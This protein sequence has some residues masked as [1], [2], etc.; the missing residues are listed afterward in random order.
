MKA[1]GYSELTTAELPDSLEFRVIWHFGWV[2]FIRPVFYVAFVLFILMANILKHLTA[3]DI[4][5]SLSGVLIMTFI[6][7]DHAAKWFQGRT[8]TLR[9]TDNELVASGN[10][11]RLFL[12]KV[13]IP[14]PEVDWL[15]YQCDILSDGLTIE[16]GEE[17]CL[18]LLPG[19]NQEQAESAADII[20]RK[21]PSIRPDMPR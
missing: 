7:L 9:V 10:L 18:C 11:G 21:F 3:L 16:Y 4:A 19:L 15:G 14:A 20:L 1:L 13:R 8:T 2:E 5:L 17:P 12:T 6:F